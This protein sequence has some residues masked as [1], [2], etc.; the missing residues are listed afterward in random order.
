V[1][2]KRRDTSRG[3]PRSFA[4]QKALAQDDNKLP[5]SAAGK[6]EIGATLEARF[7]VCCTPFMAE[8]KNK[9][10]DLVLWIITAAL[11]ALSIYWYMKPR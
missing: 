5:R 4:A 2:R 9:S 3:S 1:C 6:G 10:K 8:E 7:E 11:V